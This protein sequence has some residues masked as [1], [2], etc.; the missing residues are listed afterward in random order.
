MAIATSDPLSSRRLNE[1]ASAL[2]QIDMVQCKYLEKIDDKKRYRVKLISRDNNE[3]RR[4]NKSE[5]YDTIDFTDEESS[6]YKDL[7][8]VVKKMIE[9][10]RVDSN[11]PFYTMFLGLDRPHA[12]RVRE[13]IIALEPEQLKELLKG[14]NIYYKKRIK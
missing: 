6:G 12:A 11:Y 7:S 13:T 10:R 8:E 1:T 3:V 9:R 5:F 14:T 4:R 2:T